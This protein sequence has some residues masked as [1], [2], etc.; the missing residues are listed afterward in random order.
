ME[1]TITQ[2]THIEQISMTSNDRLKDQGSRSLGKPK[3]ATTETQNEEEFRE[4]GGGG[5]AK[6]RC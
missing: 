2:G 6:P 1:N 4:G 3:L 5:M